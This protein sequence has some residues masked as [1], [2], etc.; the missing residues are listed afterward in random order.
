MFSSSTILVLSV[1]TGVWGFTMDSVAGEFY[2]MHRCAGDML[3]GYLSC[4]NISLYNF[5]PVRRDMK[6][7][8]PGQRI[9]SGN[10]ARGMK[11]MG[12]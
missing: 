5:L 3:V 1:G 6:I 8:D 2:L 9:Y 11:H 10:G 4:T 12:V 7:P